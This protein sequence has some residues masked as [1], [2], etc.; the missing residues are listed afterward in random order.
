[1]LL[2]LLLCTNDHTAFCI[3]QKLNKCFP[4]LPII[5]ISNS[6]LTRQAALPSLAFDGAQLGRAAALRLLKMLN[7]AIPALDATISF[8]VQTDV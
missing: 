8:R 4:Q 2:M 6:F 3:H 7:I 5:S 1:M